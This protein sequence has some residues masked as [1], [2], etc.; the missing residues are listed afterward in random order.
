MKPSKRTS[1]SRNSPRRLR[2]VQAAVAGVIM[3][4]LTPRWGMQPASRATANKIIKPNDRLTSF[5]RLEIYNKQYWFRLIDNFH[6]DYPGLRAV[7]GKRRFNTL[8]KD[9]LARYSSQSFTLRNLGQFLVKFV[10]RTLPRDRLALDM[11]R[12]EWAHIIA[13]DS[14]ARPVVT[15]DELLGRDPGKL[16]LALQP[17]ITLL[18]LNYPVDD[19]LIDVKRGSSL[20]AEASNA[21]ELHRRRDRQLVRRAKPEHCF[22]V[23]H[24]MNDSVYYKR[25]DAP[26]FAI[27]RSLQRGATL[28]RACAKARGVDAGTIQ[29]WF[30]SWTEFGWFCRPIRS[31]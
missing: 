13:F 31:A 18:E 16:K 6:D 28:S 11:T 12:I 3:T 22:L 27:L 4:P 30:Q 20:R 24:R 10:E 17:Y 19:L 15:A 21:V 8:A 14:E 2:D 5:E 9:Y 25:V 7:L 23:V 1:S 26:A 29:K